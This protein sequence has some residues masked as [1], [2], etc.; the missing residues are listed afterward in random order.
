MSWHFST[1]SLQYI[2][3]GILSL[4]IAIYIFCKNPRTLEYIYFFSYGSLTSIWA[5]F[6]FFH[7]IAP[8]A[9]ASE[10]FFKVGLF[11]FQLFTAILLITILS[12]RKPRKIYLLFLAPAI[13]VGIFGF[14]T[15]IRILWSRW[16]WSY[17][18]LPT[19]MKHIYSI[20]P[21]AHI[22]GI[23]FVLMLFI[24]KYGASAL[25]KKRKIMLFGSILYMIG[26][27][28][29]NSIISVNPN[30]PPLGGVLATILFFFIAYAINLPS[31]KIIL[32]EMKV[33]LGKL[34]NFYLQFLNVFRDVIPG[35]ELGSRSFRFE[36]YLEAM[37]LKDV[38][39]PKSGK[40]TF[41]PEKINNENMGEIP[42]NILEII[43]EY[44][45]AME[46]VN[47]FTNVFVA[48]YEVLK[49]KSKDA[50]DK[51]FEQML[52]RHGGFLVKQGILADIPED[53]KILAIFKEL[54]PGKSYL[55]SEEAPNEAYSKLK[56]ALGSG[57]DGL[58][59][60]KFHPQKVRER[61]DVEKASICWLTFNNFNTENTI[62]PKNLNQLHKQISDFVKSPS[63]SV[64]LLDCFKEI[65]LV[66]GFE[67]AMN[68]LRE[69]KEIC[70]ECNANLLIS[71]NPK[72]FEEKQIPTIE[73]EL[74]E[75]K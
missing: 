73:K 25:Q 67:Y 5:F 8:T 10:L 50:A 22:I 9:N 33:P 54:H 65:V 69:I 29:S 61:Y 42:D 7:R 41:A 35:K 39:V 3:G 20:S 12:L 34:S 71:I 57:F 1:I 45:W 15:P 32:S 49:S 46:A 14:I 60:T 18:F 17:K 24:K 4:I 36:E 11:F 2:V 63:R 44:S 52:Q 19:F 59:I 53:V 68:F 27:G 58:V 40:L 72:V 62:N 26:I 6:M 55:F 23:C 21:V 37:G 30:F 47:D 28:T 48:T 56:E 70:K 64:V 13:A 16:G 31:E 51:W 74:E 43:K 66:N 75:L 38:V